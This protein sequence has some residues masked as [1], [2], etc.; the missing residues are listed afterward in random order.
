VVRV[1]EADLRAAI[2]GVVLNERLVVE[3]AGSAGVAA[4]L[5][6]YVNGGR[7]KV[8]VVLSGANIDRLVLAELISA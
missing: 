7:R 8:A 3:G 6:G 2:A 5:A 1:S 4:L